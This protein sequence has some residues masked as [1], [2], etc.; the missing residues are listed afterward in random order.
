MKKKEFILKNKKIFFLIMFFTFLS[1]AFISL[2]PISTKNIIEN[3]SNLNLENVLR[4]GSIYIISI[5][6]F[7]YFEYKKKVTIALFGYNYFVQTKQEVFNSILK[8]TP[9]K[10]REKNLG[11]VINAITKDTELVYENYIHSYISLCISIISFIVYVSYMIYLN[12]ILTII[13]ILSSAIS[14]FIP[15]IVGNKMSYMRKEYS[16]SCSE[17]IYNLEN[18]L[19]G[20]EIFNYK[21]NKYFSRKFQD[22]NQKTEEKGLN[23]LKYISFT[24]IFSGA[25]LYFINIMTFVIGMILVSTNMIKISELIAIIGFVDLVAI[26]TRDIIQLIITMKSTSDIIKKLDFYLIDENKNIQNIDSF[27]KIEIKNL[28]YSVNNFRIDDINI[29]LQKGKKYVVI[30]KNGSGKS[31]IMKLLSKRIQPNPN[32]IFID[33]KD[34]INL[35]IRDLILYLS[36]LFIINDTIDQNIKM[37]NSNIKIDDKIFSIVKG[38]EN[39]EYKSLSMGERAKV[40]IARALNSYHPV[41]ILDEFFANI[42]EKSEIDLT[43]LLIKSDKTIICIT[44]NL[45]KE[46]LN[47]FDEVIQI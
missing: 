9:K 47:M 12:W 29:N 20:V 39:Q 45:E 10:L 27:E 18:L 22:Y 34:I 23:L 5:V 36:K 6:L 7:L 11:D 41:L 15:K 40:N 32:Q 17:L 28:S 21:T 43:K 3:Y 14:F 1:T 38:I 44:H 4:Y 2:V 8:M 30:G 24:N 33:G 37:S 31:T 46:Y 13:I 42:D 16:D 25:S 35:E 26:P 19:G